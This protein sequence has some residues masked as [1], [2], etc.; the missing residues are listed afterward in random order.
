[1]PMAIGQFSIG[2]G[3]TYARWLESLALLTEF[4]GQGIYTETIL[5]HLNAPNAD[6]RNILGYLTSPQGQRFMKS[7]GQRSTLAP[8]SAKALALANQFP[9]NRQFSQ[10][11][12]YLAKSLSQLP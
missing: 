3:L 11:D 5:A 9:S 7:I 1:M 10:L 8:A 4:A 6:P 12:E 2:A